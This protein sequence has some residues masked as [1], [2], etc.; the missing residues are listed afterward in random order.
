MELEIWFFD[1]KK[2]KILRGSHQILLV[3]FGPSNF[4]VGEAVIA[5]EH[6]R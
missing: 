5:Q 3:G 1:K 2:K 4:Y 6:A